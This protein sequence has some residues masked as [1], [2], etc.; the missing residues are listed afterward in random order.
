MTPPNNDA[1]TLRPPPDQPPPDAAPTPLEPDGQAVDG[2]PPQT[3]MNKLAVAAMV[4][5]LLG[6]LGV[7]GAVLGF[8][9]LRQIRTTGQR[10]RS[11]AI[12]GITASVFWCVLGFAMAMSDM[13]HEREPPPVAG[14]G[15]S[16]P[17]P[18]TAPGMRQWYQLKAGDC[19]D[20]P[21]EELVTAVTLIDCD[22]AHNT[23]ITYR[24]DLSI[25]AWPGQQALEKKAT[26]ICGRGTELLRR[27]PAPRP[28]DQ[29][30]VQP[31]EDAWNS[32]IRMV[33]CL[34]TAQDGALKR[35]VLPG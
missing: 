14:D 20:T 28:V 3:D 8:G 19:L 2:A 31:D 7:L 10:G 6:C 33:L 1:P 13:A 23:E 11:Q 4:T 26:K 24:S 15:V 17:L 22:K 29:W 35:S 25:S 32:G 5:G 30:F 21:R 27:H 16:A 9:A 18:S 34:V 12:G